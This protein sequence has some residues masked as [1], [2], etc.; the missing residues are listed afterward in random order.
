MRR[1]VVG[2]AVLAACMFAPSVSS[3][4]VS[5]AAE[6]VAPAWR[7]EVLDV[8]ALIATAATPGSSTGPTYASADPTEAPTILWDRD[9]HACY[10][11]EHVDSDDVDVADGHVYG[12]FF[13]CLDEPSDWVFL[14]E[15][16]DEW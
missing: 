14:V 1:A 16:Y 13:G 3:A 9:L 10:G 6:D 8:G 12:A 5:S 11:E 4:S 7:P 15:T 2:L